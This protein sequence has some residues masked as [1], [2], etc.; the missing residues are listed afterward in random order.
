MYQW[1]K[2][3]AD[4]PFSDILVPTVEVPLAVVENTDSLVT[5]L[6]AIMAN[7]LPGFV[8]RSLNPTRELRGDNLHLRRAIA[9]HLQIAGYE[10][11][12]GPVTPNLSIQPDVGPGIFHVDRRSGDTVNTIDIH[13]TTSGKGRVSIAESG[14]NARL[15]AFKRPLEKILS[16]TVLGGETDP[17]ILM[18][19]LH[20]AEINTGDHVI[21]PL[22][23]DRGPIWHRFDTTVAPREANISELEL[24]E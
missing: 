12:D 13:T 24:V 22:T 23:N 20:C 11:E 8:I 19:T 1:Q 14:H 7:L 2:Y 5:T 10:F 4:S 15:I 3:E 17:T 6:Q 9:E 21:F 16:K 18:P